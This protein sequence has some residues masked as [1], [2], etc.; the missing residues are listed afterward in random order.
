MDIE[1]LK[2][3]L[4]DETFSQ[5]Q[6]HI[7][8]L[9]GQRDAARNESI[10][11]RKALKAR[12]AELEGLQAK[13]FERLGIDTAE[14]L[15]TLP[16]ARGQAEAMK[17]VEVKLKRLEREAA[18]R[19]KAF[20]ELNTKHR[21]AIQQATL[22]KALSAHQFIDADLVSSY[23]NQRVVW[24]EDQPFY[25]AD[26]NKLLPLDE[27]VKLLATT[28]PHLLK[29]QGVG[30]SG[31]TGARGNGQ[32]GTQ[33]MNRADFDSLTPKAQMDFVK[34]GGQLQ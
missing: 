29:A 27:G 20:D 23:L 10:Q 34:A 13:V 31:Y 24:E 12:V 32:A 18:D 8:D 6:A 4:E 25:R 28:K 1:A 22:Q 30:G 2:T 11:G 14:E 33:I 5:L 19:A 9:T 17:Q 15:D 21:S 16:D 7:A 3:K 26:D